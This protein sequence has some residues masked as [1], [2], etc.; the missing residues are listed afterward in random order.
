MDLPRLRVGVYATTT[1]T[2]LFFRQAVGRLVRWV[3]GKGG[4]QSAYMFIPDDPRIREYA[5]EIKRARR[6]KLDEEESA[7]ETPEEKEQPE[8]REQLEAATTGGLR[9]VVGARDVL[10]VKRGA[11]AKRPRDRHRE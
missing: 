1:I 2:D 6:H 4:R 9:L 10:R 8:E 7:E 3:Q 11:R 5:L